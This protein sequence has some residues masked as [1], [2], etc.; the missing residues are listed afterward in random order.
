MLRDYQVRAVEA[1]RAA[2][3]AG[4]R[5][6]LVLPT[7]AGKTVVA[8]ALSEG[9]ALVVAHTRQIV[10]QTARRFAPCGVLMGAGSSGLDSPVVVA[11]I[12]TLARRGAPERPV[13]IVDEAHHA[14]AAT[15][16][17]LILRHPRPVGLTATPERLD[18]RGLGLAGFDVLIEPATFRTLADEHFLITPNVYAAP[19]MADMSKL[20]VV[21]GDYSP[22]SAAE[23]MSDLDGSIAEHWVKHGRNRKGVAFAATVDH[24]DRL[25]LALR[26]VGCRAVSVSGKSPRA[27]RTEA[28]EALERGDLDVL[29]NCNLLGEGWDLPRLDLAILARP[30]KSL[31][32]HRQQIGRVTRPAPLK[33]IPKVL[34]HAGNTLR[35]GFIEDPRAWSLDAKR[36]RSRAEN[37]AKVCLR[38][39]AVYPSE[40]IRC[41]QC[42]FQSK[43][44]PPVKVFS[45]SSKALVQVKK[46]EDFSDIPAPTDLASVVEAGNPLV[47]SYCDLVFMAWSRG[48]RIGWARHRYKHRHKSW[49]NPQWSSLVE[50]AYGY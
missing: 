27:A 15:Y 31:T 24:A 19:R 25:A 3:A 40:L 10:E 16:L 8:H 26:G 29:V 1:V 38:C 32:V 2:W 41:N 39:Y 47:R 5:P 9:G 50:Q 20:R 46:R 4:Q 23:S 42:G 13:L 34:D 7:G 35:L 14:C 21:G 36:K 48:Y 18:G 37:V 11:S 33:P 49:P 30:T 45:E 17:A 43:H 22:A 6:L 12:Q 44:A 28:I